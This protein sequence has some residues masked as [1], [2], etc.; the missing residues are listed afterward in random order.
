M[1]GGATLAGKFIALLLRVTLMLLSIE[2]KFCWG[3]GLLSNLK[4]FWIGIFMAG[5]TIF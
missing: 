4:E 1:S 3:W 2:L 5:I